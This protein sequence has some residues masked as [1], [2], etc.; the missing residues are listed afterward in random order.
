M[1]KQGFTLIETMIVVLIF[2]FLFSG[3]L[4]VLL[5]SDRSW[6]IGRDKLIEQQQLR[7][8][9]ITMGSLLRQSSA[10]WNIGG[11]TYGASISGGNRRID[12][13]NPVFDSIGQISS[14]KKVTF[15]PNPENPGQLLKKEGTD[16]YTVIAADVESISFQG[17]C[18]GCA[19]FGCAAVAIDCPIVKIQL[20]SRRQTTFDL[21][22][23]ITFRNRNSLLPA[24]TIVVEPQEGEF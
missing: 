9:M 18:A 13:Y 3:I 12:F 17:G 7:R 23:Q 11:V 24:G 4:T 21:S 2:A 19:T 5:N 22:S 15:K 16:G 14:L 10:L 6:S 8:A 20:R 1:I